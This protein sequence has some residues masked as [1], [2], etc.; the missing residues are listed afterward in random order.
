MCS[1]QAS[2]YVPDEFWTDALEQCLTA[3]ISNFKKFEGKI[4]KEVYLDDFLRTLVS[5]GIRETG[6]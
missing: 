1:P 4:N 5:F 2:S 6:S 3:A